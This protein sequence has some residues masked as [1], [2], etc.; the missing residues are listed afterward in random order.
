ML[1][2]LLPLPFLDA[3]EYRV[4][5]ASTVATISCGSRVGGCFCCFSGVSRYSLVASTFYG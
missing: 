1:P 2:L 4:P 5:P 3:D